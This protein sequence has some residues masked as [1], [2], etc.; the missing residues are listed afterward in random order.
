MS[1][2][3]E[4]LGQ[5]QN[6]LEGL[7][8]SPGLGTPMDPPG[9]ADEHGWGEGGLGFIPW[10]NATVTRLWI[11]CKKW[12]DGCTISFEVTKIGCT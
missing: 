7:Y 3:K 9:R 8:F 11:R 5:T 1:N 4:T 2:Q 12:M 10:P 6:M